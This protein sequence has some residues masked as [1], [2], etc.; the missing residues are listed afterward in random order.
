MRPFNNLGFFRDHKDEEIMN[1]QI[2][3]SEPLFVQTCNGHAAVNLIEDIVRVRGENQNQIVY[4]DKTLPSLSKGIYTGFK[5]NPGNSVTFT[6]DLG[7][8]LY[9]LV[10][11]S[12]NSFKLSEIIVQD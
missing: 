6:T 1:C 11:E 9:I 3:V 2:L 10:L 4:P 5:A 12:I 7:D 8:K